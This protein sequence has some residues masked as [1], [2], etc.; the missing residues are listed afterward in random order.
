MKHQLNTN[1]RLGRNKIARKINSDKN[2]KFKKW[3]ECIHAEHEAT[4]K[5]YQTLRES[6]ESESKNRVH[7]D[8]KLEVLDLSKYEIKGWYY[9][10]LFLTFISIGITSFL[11]PL[12]ILY[13]L[14]I[15]SLPYCK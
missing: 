5:A 8:S 15:I 6:I 10:H 14:G 9:N 3:V 13:F 2:V 4:A 7:Y 11:F 1:S 12:F